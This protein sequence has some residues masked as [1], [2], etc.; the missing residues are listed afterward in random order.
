MARTRTL[1]AGLL[2]ALG[3]TGIAAA[4]APHAAASGMSPMLHA[5]D[6]PVG[7]CRRMRQGAAEAEVWPSSWAADHVK[8][9]DPAASLPQA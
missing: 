7:Y 6:L 4:L 8:I 1:A 2:L 3:L 5:P 9:I